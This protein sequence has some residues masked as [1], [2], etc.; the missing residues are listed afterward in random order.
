M[1]DSPLPPI[2]CEVTVASA[3][4]AAYRRFVHDFAVWWPRATH[5]IGGKRVRA[6]VFEARVRG[7]IYEE[8]VDGR[9][10]QW[11]RVL[12]VE[13]PARIRFCFHPSRDESSAQT[14][15]IRFLA[16]AGG[17]TRV[18]LTAWD[19]EKWGAGAARARKGY[20]LGWGY[21]LRQWAGQR[22]A[23]MLLVDG[24]AA[25]ARIVHWLRG[26]TAAAIRRAGGEIDPAPR[27]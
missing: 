2:E 20:R 17:G 10:F 24:L 22:T 21:V 4:D 1:V 13:E 7:R 26:G 25:V 8:H 5:S 19:W 23:G 12:E 18:V 11:G 14:V 6:I 9:R 15:E 3:P 27:G 16:R